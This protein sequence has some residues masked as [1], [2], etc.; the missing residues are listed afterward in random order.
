MLETPAAGGAL[1]ILDYLLDE[2]RTTGGLLRVADLAKKGRRPWWRSVSF[3]LTRTPTEVSADLGIQYIGQNIDRA[4]EH[5]RKA[6]VHCDELSEM[7]PTND[8]VVGLVVGLKDAGTGSVVPMLQH[9]VIP[10]PM[11][12]LA[13]HLASVVDTIRECDRLVVAARNRAILQRL[14]ETSSAN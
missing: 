11:S 6:L 1:T 4:R 9:D 5:W 13:K 3:G 12:E 8:I 10:G 7:F 14:R 2:I